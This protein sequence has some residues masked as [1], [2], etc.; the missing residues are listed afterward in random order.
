MGTKKLSSP[1]RAERTNASCQK[2]PLATE[3]QERE[4]QHSA[5]LQSMVAWAGHTHKITVVSCCCLP[6]ARSALSLFLHT[7][8]EGREIDAVRA[9][10]SSGGRTSRKR[11]KPRKEH[12]VCALVKQGKI[13]FFLVLCWH[14]SFVD[15]LPRALTDSSHSFVGK[16]RISR[17][18]DLRPPA[19]SGLR[20]AIIRVATQSMAA[21]WTLAYI[22]SLIC[23]VTRRT[24]N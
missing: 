12:S 20:I 24:T 13:L 17:S 2:P 22:P 15:R 1:W 6:I 3:T 18:P 23:K 16:K 8:S 4:R 10:C 21:A 14:R 11:A 5:V 9:L 19:G 7:S